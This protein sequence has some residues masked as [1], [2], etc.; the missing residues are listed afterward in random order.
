MTG[1]RYVGKRTGRH[2][3]VARRAVA[4][5]S[6][7]AV[8]C[9]AAVI[10]SEAT[11][12]DA[13]AS[14]SWAWNSTSKNPAP[15]ETAE[16]STDSFAQRYGIWPDTARPKDGPDLDTNRVQLGL[17][18]RS[19]EDGW[20]SA[21]RFFKFRSNTGPHTGYLW[22][23]DGTKL[24][25]VE[26][27]GESSDGW[28]TATLS[29]PVR[30]SSG[31]V[32][33]A[34]YIAPRGRYADDRYALTYQVS[35]AGLT[36]LG[37]VY[38]YGDGLPTESWKDSNYFVDVLFAPTSSRASV[39]PSPTK[40]TS[41]T[42][43]SPRSSVTSHTSTARPADSTAATVTSR[44]HIWPTTH[45]P[46]PPT[47]TPAKP[48]ASA[49]SS[50]S[51]ATSST[52]Q[53]SSPTTTSS[54]QSTTN[55]PPSSATQS[56]PP[57][58]S[59]SSPA[60]STTSPSASGSQKRNCAARPSAC[61]YPD[62]T[63][64]GVPSGRTLKSVPG[65]IS[66]GAGWHYDSRGW[67]E[68]DGNGAVLDGISTSASIDVTAS[69]VTIENSKITVTGEGWGIAARHAANLVIRNNNISSPANTG[70]NRLMVGIKDIYGDS[71][72]MQVIGNNIWN[73]STG[74]Q[75]ES[76]LIEG[77]YIHDLGY[78]SGDHLNGTTSNGGTRPLTIRHNTIFNKYEQTDAI[79]LFQDFGIQAN[80]TIDDNL[81]AG[82]G[83]TI[84]GGGG[85]D[86][87]ATNISITNNRFARVFYA[88]SGYYGPVAAFDR[89]GNNVWSG[90]VW[91]DTGAVVS[92]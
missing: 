67:I 82:G 76:G 81:L 52:S 9:A 75:I 78:T 90:N 92:N 85:S 4:G 47:R 32:Y 70:P 14:K 37:S 8:L 56:A 19:A 91:D 12:A 22:T 23:G 25:S 72:G 84:Y 17:R 64:T 86:G 79:S 51:S 45:R 41:T 30:I 42:A 46:E 18:F 62:A 16:A 24:A 29:Q 77:N 69:N 53:T 1:H 74:V 66:S 83:Y 6:A 89:G 15:V 43:T 38:T 2:R 40:W 88:N 73:T 71:T 49:Q 60:P 10:I 35:R 20:V 61:G 68:V 65:D 57:T 44:H 5:L 27:Q 31:K 11:P 48:A 28:Q 59:T 3:A 63:N 34:S 58:T 13:G 39:P 54:Q 87:P 21:I 80:R 26:F 36:A 50:S 55:K 33:V 7:L